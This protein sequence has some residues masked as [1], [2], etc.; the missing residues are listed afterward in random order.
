MTI[1]IMIHLLLKLQVNIIYTSMDV[2]SGDEY[3]EINVSMYKVQRKIGNLSNIS[4]NV[5]LMPMHLRMMLLSLTFILRC[6]RMPS[7]VCFLI[8]KSS[9]T[10]IL[11]GILSVDF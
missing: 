11:I 9:N 4:R 2:D 6:S 3:E 5:A 7:L 8:T 1:V 10:N